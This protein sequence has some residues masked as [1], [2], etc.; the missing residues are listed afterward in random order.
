[1]Q[2]RGH[3]G[4]CDHNRVER[5][6]GVHARVRRL[7]DGRGVHT[8]TLTSTGTKSEHG[9]GETGTAHVCTPHTPAQSEPNSATPGRTQSTRSRTTTHTCTLVEVRRTQRELDL[10]EM[11]DVRAHHASDVS[12]TWQ[13][14]TA[15]GGGGHRSTTWGHHTAH[16]YPQTPTQWSRRRTGCHAS[17][18]ILTTTCDGDGGGGKWTHKCGQT[19]GF[20]LVTVTKSAP[21]MEGGPACVCPK[22]TA[23][24]GHWWDCV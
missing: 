14:R 21:Q 4:C 17:L 5:Y 15:L 6:H 8:N 7:S 19:S 16:Q 1:M 2:T 23:Q 13:W 9:H 22:T 12:H 3:L 11:H 10:R 18:R 20:V 24:V